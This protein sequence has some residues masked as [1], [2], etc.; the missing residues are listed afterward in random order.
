MD[1][2]HPAGCGQLY[3]PILL[4]VCVAR[5]GLGAYGL[6]L[7]KV[8]ESSARD[9]AHPRC[10]REAGLARYGVRLWAR[11]DGPWLDAN[12]GPSAHA[13]QPPHASAPCGRVSLGRGRPFLSAGRRQIQR[14]RSLVAN[15][16]T[17]ALPR[18]TATASIHEALR[19]SYV[20]TYPHL[21]VFHNKFNPRFYVTRYHS[22][23][24]FSQYSHIFRA[25]AA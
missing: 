12:S 9:C 2:S 1:V 4:A 8:T 15:G 5:S 11:R 23:F 13:I 16:W 10:G 17:V 6:R 3:A 24:L 25:A 7:C 22:T 18:R 21:K 20:R 19:P 14:R